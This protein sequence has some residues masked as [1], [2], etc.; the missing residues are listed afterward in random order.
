[1]GRGFE[2]QG[3]ISRP[4]DPVAAGIKAALAGAGLGLSVSV[5]IVG[6]MLV[7]YGLRRE[8][9]IVLAVCAGGILVLAIAFALAGAAWARV[10]E[11]AYDRVLETP[12]DD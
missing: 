2:L 4:D 8:L 1:M 10:Q 9:P 3:L 12:P 5:T 7:R 11:W 6:T